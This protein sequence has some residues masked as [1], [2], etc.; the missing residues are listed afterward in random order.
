[1]YFILN[2][3][4]IDTTFSLE[5]LDLYLGTKLAVKEVDSHV[6]LFQTHLS[7]PST[8]VS[9]LIIELICFK[10][11]MKKGGLYFLSLA[12]FQVLNATC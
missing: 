10:I 9:F 5:I 2:N 1:M 6:Q 4:A 3:P 7:V 8:F 12:T 11:K